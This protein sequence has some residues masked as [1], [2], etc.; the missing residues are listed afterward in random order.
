LLSQLPTA[1]Y[2]NMQEKMKVFLFNL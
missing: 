2:V 1:F